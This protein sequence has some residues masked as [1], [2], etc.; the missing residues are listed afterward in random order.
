MK[1]GVHKPAGRFAAGLLSLALL[2]VAGAT[3]ASA[4]PPDS[5]GLTATY[6][7]G[8]RLSFANRTLV[9][10][11]VATV[12]NTTSA[13]VGRLSFNLLPARIGRL[14]LRSV[15]VAGE[16]AVAK[17]S[18]QTI[19]VTL[20]SALAVG[21]KARVRIAYRATLRTTT[22]DKNFLF[23]KINGIVTAYRWVPWLSRA[24]KFDR[25][26]FGDPFVTAIS[27]RVTVRITTDKKAV[28]AATGARK[29]VDGLT[30]TFVAR[31][32]RD[33]N[34][35]ASTKYKSR[36][37]TWNGVKIIVYYRSLPPDKVLTWAKRAIKRYSNKVGA[38]PYPQFRVAESSG[39]IGMESPQMIWI[40]QTTKRVNLAYLI[41]HETAH[42]WF[43]G[44]V[45][46]DRAREPFA[47]EGI[48]EFLARDLIS[49]FRASKCARKQLDMTIYEY[50]RSCY[51]EVI[52]IQGAKYLKA[53][54]K[55]V[56][57][58]AFWTGV[59]DYYATYRWEMPGTRKLLDT[60]DAAA[61][62]DAPSHAGRFESLYPSN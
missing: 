56:G 10:S 34:F 52:Y 8:A 54:R 2:L 12:T 35:A 39:G 62:P 49:A 37:T 40:P 17:V 42:Q 58:E 59:R 4:A 44:V 46:S 7:V 3:P 20:N 5:L 55:R 57:A 53:Y 26:N 32:V 30:Q 25:P 14:Q 16:A 18:G 15:T 61:G 11:S 24:V 33:F 51:Y 29:S 41:A 23:A 6:D 50:S 31:N 36:S 19:V 43:Y 47:D 13:K 48:A 27:P 9:V 28:I 21:G 22:T 38:Y 45:G 60:L 1:E